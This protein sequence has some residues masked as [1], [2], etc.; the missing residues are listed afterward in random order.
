MTDKKRNLQEMALDYANDMTVFS[1]LVCAIIEHA[2]KD[3]K[4][5]IQMLNI[6]YL[7]YSRQSK[8]GEKA[9]DGDIQAQMAM[10]RI[11]DNMAR[12]IGIINDDESIIFKTLNADSSGMTCSTEITSR[13]DNDSDENE[14][15]KIIATASG[16]AEA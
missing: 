6:F 3:R 1:K 10:Q 13:F 9:K 7:M 12:Q 4:E 11:T 2:S 16:H 15:E 8:M 14:M 5:Q